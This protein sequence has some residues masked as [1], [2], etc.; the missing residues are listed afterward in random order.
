SHPSLS[1][2][3]T[4]HL[5][6]ILC[7]SWQTPLPY[8]EAQLQ[9]HPPE[10]C[11][12]LGIELQIDAQD[13]D[14]F[15]EQHD[16]SLVRE[17]VIECL[18]ER[19]VAHLVRGGPHETL[20]YRYDVDRVAVR[21]A[22]DVLERDVED[23][24]IVVNRSYPTLLFLHNS[25]FTEPEDGYLLRKELG[26][27]RGTLDGGLDKVTQADDICTLVCEAYLAYLRLPRAAVCEALIPQLRGVPIPVSAHARLPSPVIPDDSAPE[28]VQD[29]GVSYEAGSERKRRPS[30]RLVER[31]EP[32]KRG[33]KR[34]SPYTNREHLSYKKIKTERGTRVSLNYGLWERPTADGSQ[35]A[36]RR[37]SLVEAL[38]KTLLPEGLSLPS[39]TPEAGKPAP[40]EHSQD[41][42]GTVLGT[43]AASFGVGAAIT[44]GALSALQLL[45]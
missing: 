30:P 32:S 9:Q 6:A 23:F 36:A 38:L 2:L 29:D 35:P 13:C 4:H 34:K 33:A 27:L 45:R 15:I 18:R 20:V 1:S 3:S 43:R 12:R 17:Q 8:P 26:T 39:P 41:T 44:W 42:V 28:E 19:G 14:A 7:T 40:A 16:V 25:I 10:G 31:A 11:T 21:A 22:V 5:N 24:H 37:T